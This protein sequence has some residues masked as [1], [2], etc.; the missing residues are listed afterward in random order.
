[1]LMILATFSLTFL[2][3]EIDGP[4]NIISIIRNRLMKL[5]FVGVF[6]YKLLSCYYCLGCWCGAAVFALAA[7]PWSVGNFL[8]WILVGG[9]LGT[10]GDS[11]LTKLNS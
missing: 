3:K 8:L 5:R 7:V 9:I 2:I 11:I 10:F 1:M 4:F 6:F